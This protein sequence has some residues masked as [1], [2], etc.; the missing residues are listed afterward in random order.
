VLCVAHPVQETHFFIDLGLLFVAALGGAVLAQLARQP[1]I[2]GY[3]LA[4]IVVGPFTPGLTIADPEPFHWF[5]EVGVILLMFSIGMEFSVGQLLGVGAVA[6][7]G[8][9]A[10]IILITLLTLGAGW[11][12][13]WT[14]TE[15]MLVGASLSVA[16]TMV[17][18]KFLLEQKAVGSAC[19][20][21]VVG[22]TLVEDIAVVV[23]TLLIPAFG[24]SSGADLPSLARGLALA[25]LM[26]VPIV[27]L[28]RRVVPRLL[29]V[30]ARTANDE[31]LLIAAVTIAMATA[32]LTVLIGLSHAVGAFLA[33][34]VISES[35][36]AHR[37]LDRVLPIRDVFVAV[38]FVSVGM[39]IRPASLYAELPTVVTMVLLVTVGKFA[40]W[41]LVVR[42]GGYDTPTAL[43]AALGLTQIGEF[44]YI[45]AKAGLDHG[46]LTR[47]L[48]DAILGTSLVTILLNALTFRRFLRR[49]ATRPPGA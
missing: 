24:P 23:M 5:A 15:S 38:F 29:T 9:P 2:V 3:V 21:A 41:A 12:L 7:V 27:W 43:R 36:A 6:A 4:G 18:M 46:L 14:P 48:Y 37:A 39:L 26:L 10:G 47:R 34:M 49:A 1:L 20:R 11:L 17:L 33:G 16:S 13:G 22:I 42:L 8:G 19:G 32:A 44:S 28:A 31:L 45:L 25:T 35:A 40:V 30:V